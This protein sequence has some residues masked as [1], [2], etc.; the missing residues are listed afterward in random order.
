MDSHQILGTAKVVV[1]FTKIVLAEKETYFIPYSP[2][3]SKVL[4]TFP[5]KAFFQIPLCSDKV[6]CELEKVGFRLDQGLDC[7]HPFGKAVNIVLG[8]DRGPRQSQESN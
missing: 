8:R 1:S 7:H 6:L 4:D 2:F 5:K 3:A